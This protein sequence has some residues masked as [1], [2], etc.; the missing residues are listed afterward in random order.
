LGRI[1]EPGRRGFAG[2]AGL[3]GAGPAG[4]IDGEVGGPAAEEALALVARGDE[5]AF[6]VLVSVPS[7]MI[8]SHL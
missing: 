7:S 1:A 6:G 3:P 8:I 5:R 4:A 2:Q